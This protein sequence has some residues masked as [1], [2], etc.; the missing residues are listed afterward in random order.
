MDCGIS[1]NIL[2]LSGIELE[3]VIKILSFM[4]RAKDFQFQP[5][6]IIIGNMTSLELIKLSGKFMP[7]N[8]VIYID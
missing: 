7:L 8:Q 6:A 1:K 4:I 3:D 2:M 5:L